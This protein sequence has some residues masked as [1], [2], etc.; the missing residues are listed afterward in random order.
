MLSIELTVLKMLPAAVLK[1]NMKT[2][3]FIKEGVRPLAVLSVTLLWYFWINVRLDL[4]L[5][6]MKTM[7]EISKPHRGY[8]RRS[9]VPP[10]SIIGTSMFPFKLNIIFYN[11]IKYHLSRQPCQGITTYTIYQNDQVHGSA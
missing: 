10:F 5:I 11:R 3:I 4:D 9:P 6:T 1:P 7:K 8:A 2:K